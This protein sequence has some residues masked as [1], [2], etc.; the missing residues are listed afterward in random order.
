MSES[1]LQEDVEVAINAYERLIGYPATRTREMIARY[2][3]VPALTRLVSD[4]KIQSGL[5]VLAK[6][7]KLDL[8][9]EAVIVRHKV[10]FSK[11]A[12]QA[13]EWRLQRAAAGDFS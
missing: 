1:K 12:V 9:F 8:S 7:G 11:A 6:S 4:S 3:T 13:A 5:K 2:G 10:V